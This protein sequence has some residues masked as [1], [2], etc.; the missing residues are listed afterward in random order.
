MTDNLTTIG[1]IA[2]IFDGPHATPNKTDEG[3]YFLNI[4][5]LQ[6]GRLAL[7]ASAHVSNEDFIRWT[8][9]VTPRDGD[10]LFSYETRLGEAALM[11]ANIKACLGRRMGLL[12]PM[13][14]KVM[15]EFLLYSYIAP[16]F[17]K[18][19]IA[20]TIKGATVERISISE[21]GKFTLRLPSITEQ[22]E[23]ASV[24]SALDA[25][26]DLNQ[27][28]NSELE[29]LAKT[30]Y[31][32]WFVQFDFPDAKGRPY[33]T[34]GG[35]MIWNDA[36]K[37]EIP[38]GWEVGML[39]SWIHIK[40]GISYTSSDLSKSGAPLINLNSFNLDGTIKPHGTKWFSGKFR[41][42]QRIAP[43]ELVV[44]ITDVTRNA[45]IIGKSFVVPDLF[46]ESPLISCD[47][48][49]ISG[50]E[51]FPVFYLEQLF[52]SNHYHSYIR[53]FASGTLVLHL[54]LNGMNVFSGRKVLD[55]GFDFV[56]LLFDKA[57]VFFLGEDHAERP[58][59][60]GKN[61]P[62]ETRENDPVIR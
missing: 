40:R 50:G 53:H 39:G 21:I 20:N 8:K 26:I 13:R 38:A 10:L 18:E 56:Y 1:E 29:A 52:N 45:D 57:Q 5:S 6:N 12:R 42:E 44:A 48:V 37:R 55:L 58:T 32:Y 22:Q 19:I 4:A 51:H 23:I 11:P 49:A 7:D 47:V 2:E 14:N 25:K 54:D 59:G 31:D 17:Q 27:R 62:A 24:L 34:S 33:K 30:I 41:D 43:E 61:K 16:H 60:A 9:R 36:L 15:P 35:K 46:G 3:P 28:I